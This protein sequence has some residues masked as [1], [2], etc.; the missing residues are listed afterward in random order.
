MTQS[1]RMTLTYL[2]KQLLDEDGL[3]IEEYNDDEIRLVIKR[4]KM[5]LVARK[6]GN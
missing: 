6:G 2:Y 3:D 5:V 1:Q 4:L